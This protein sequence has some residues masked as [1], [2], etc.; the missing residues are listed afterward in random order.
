MSLVCGTD[1]SEPSSDAVTVAARLAAR[2][3]QRLHLVHALELGPVREDDGL[4]SAAFSH[5]ERRLAGLADRAGRYGA[6]I[7]THIKT[8]SP[9]EVLLTV[10]GEM[11]A[12]WIVVAALGQHRSGAL[13]LGSHAER[14]AQRAQVPV[15]VVREAGPFE[16]WASGSRPLRV[17]LGADATQASEH[18]LRWLAGLAA[19][20]P[21][22]VTAAFLYWPPE[23]FKRLGL[24][25]IRSFLDPDPTVTAALEK[26]LGARLRAHGL[27]DEMGQRGK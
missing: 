4:A 12:K 22:E 5:A 6:K 1:F 24:P 18:A 23:E 10:A 3:G 14:L 2:L 25:G 16:A 27:A 17:L 26:E 9:D 11:D 20:G 21:C 15:L 7:T 13:R 19:I 8:G